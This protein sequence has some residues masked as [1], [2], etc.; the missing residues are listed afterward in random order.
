MDNSIEDVDLIECDL[1]KG[2]LKRDM[3]NTKC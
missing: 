1:I 3:V 2:D